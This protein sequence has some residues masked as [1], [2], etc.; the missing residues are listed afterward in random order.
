MDNFGERAVHVTGGQT[1]DLI[2]FLTETFI[3][4]EPLWH[5]RSAF[6]GVMIDITAPP[7]NADKTANSDSTEAFRSALE[8]IQN[9][10]GGRL[11]IAS[12]NYA[13]ADSIDIPFSE[14]LAEDDGEGGAV[15]YFTASQA[16]KSLRRN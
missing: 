4:R 1:H 14:I 7:Y 5:E 11:R 16:Q 10:G 8:E 6:S 12:G 2:G 3:P 13:V 9:H 15:L